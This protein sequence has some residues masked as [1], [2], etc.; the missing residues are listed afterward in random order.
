MK[1]KIVV[2]DEEKCDGCG[3]C[4]P[5]CHE[6][7]LQIVNGKAKLVSDI[8]CDGLGDCLGHC[9]KD[10]ITVEEREA[11]DFDP[12]AVEH[13]LKVLKHKKSG[14]CALADGISLGGCPGSAARALQP[15]TVS[16]NPV[17]NG[18]YSSQLR[19]WPVQ[20]RLVPE[21]APYFHEADLLL[22]ADCV[23]FALD[24]FHSRYLKDRVAVIGCPK[25]DDGAYYAAKLSRI[26]SFNDVKSITV[27]YMEV[28]CCGGLLRIARAALDASG[29]EIPLHLVQVGIN[30]NIIR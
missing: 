16:K 19:T 22:C 9:P 27:L 18:Q 28:P 24:G 17:D 30:G 2:I 29:K 25:L 21:S 12:V 26:L 7:A 23:P 3:L 15:E 6:G 14:G 1:R 13:R 8:Y 5:A 4:V 11:E 10:A 20:L